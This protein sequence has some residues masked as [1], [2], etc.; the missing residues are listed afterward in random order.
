MLTKSE[1]EDLA[2]LLENLGATFTIHY[3]ASDGEGPQFEVIGG[4]PVHR[5]DRE[6]TQQAGAGL[7][8]T[9]FVVP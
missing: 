9:P 2:D 6:G 7:G 3:V 4:L 1:A 8:Q 5:P